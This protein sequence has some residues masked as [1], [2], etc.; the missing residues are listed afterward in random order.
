MG[1]I[2]VIIPVITLICTP[3]HKPPDFLWLALLS[4]SY[5]HRSWSSRSRNMTP[6]GK[7][8]NAGLISLTE[9]TD[10]N[11]GG[12]TERV[13]PPAALQF[14]PFCAAQNLRL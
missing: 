11:K 6:R 14:S 12:E 3:C 1:S 5:T 2:S 4:E 8:K 10:N 7:W 9:V 13:P